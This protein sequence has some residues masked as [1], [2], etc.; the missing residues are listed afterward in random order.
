MDD[1][2]WKMENERMMNDRIDDKID[3]KI[4]WK[5]MIEIFHEIYWR[6]M[7]QIIMRW[8]ILMSVGW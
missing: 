3:E 6:W 8:M 2:R 1:E 7:N 5:W 4:Y